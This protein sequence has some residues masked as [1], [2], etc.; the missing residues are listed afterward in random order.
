MSQIK[1]IYQGFKN[2][3]FQNEEINKT[4]EERL[5]ICF[6]CPVREGKFCSKL[7]GGCGCM[8]AAK[9]RSSGSKCPKDKW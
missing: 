2:L 3:V 6:E 5:K 7:K 8:L 1:E 4:A 9:T